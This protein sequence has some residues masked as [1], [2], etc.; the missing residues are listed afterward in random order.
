MP[1]N[2]ILNEAEQVDVARMHALIDT[3]RDELHNPPTHAELVQLASR[4]QTNVRHPARYMNTIRKLRRTVYVKPE[5]GKE[6]DPEAIIQLRRERLDRMFACPS[7]AVTVAKGEGIGVE[8]EFFCPRD[9]A[10]DLDKCKGDSRDDDGKL[11]GVSGLRLAY[12]SSVSGR[13]NCDDICRD[14]EA[15]LFFGYK[16]WHRLYEATERLREAGCDVNRTCGLHVHIDCRDISNTAAGTRAKRLREALPWLKRMVPSSR[17]SNTYC[18]RDSGRYQPINTESLHR[19]STV[20]VRLHSGTLDADKIRNW[21][22]V[23][24]FIALRHGGGRNRPT[25]LTSLDEFLEA[26]EPEDHIKQWVVARTN[27]FNPI[28]GTDGEDS[29]QEN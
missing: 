26:P 23:V 29:E 5:A 6:Y 20:E 4:N 21:I 19:H 28:S 17:A 18:N 22:E 1:A 3:N 2:T 10:R 14:R 8:M 11:V 25:Y 15:R 24:R 13:D 7:N 9:R 12:D 16:R 27:T